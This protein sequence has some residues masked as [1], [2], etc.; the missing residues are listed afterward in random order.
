MELAW[1]A[2]VREKERGRRK[3]LVDIDPRYYRPTEVELLIGDPNESKG[4]ARLIP[5]TKFSELVKIIGESGL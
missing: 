4:E 5:E 1:S 2:T 3:V